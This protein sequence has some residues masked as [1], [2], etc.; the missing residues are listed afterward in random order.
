MH[1]GPEIWTSKSLLSHIR[2]LETDRPDRRL[3]F[4]IGAGASV[5]SGIP[6]G[7]RLV[8]RWLN[9]L[10]ER[11]CHGKEPLQEWATE[12]NL[13][14]P[15]FDYS[16]RAEFYPQVFERRYRR[17]R[18][19]GYEALEKIMDRAKPSFG[20]SVLAQI[21]A[22]KRHNVVVTT[23]FDN[24]VADAM[25][26]YSGRHPLMVGHE[27]LSGYAR[28]RLSRPLV[29]KIHRDL[30]INPINDPAGTSELATGW[31]SA[32]TELFKHHT[33]IVIGY[34]GNDG[35]LMGFLETLPDDHI[36][37]GLFWTYRENSGKP[38]GRIADVVARHKGALVPIIGFDEFMLQLREIF[39]LE[40]LTEHI[41]KQAD[42]HL[43]RYREQTDNL[44]KTIDT[45]SRPPNRDTTEQTA[46][47]QAASSLAK[48]QH[49]WWEWE[50]K[51]RSEPDLNKREAIYLE[52]LSQFPDNLEL[53]GNLANFMMDI[54]QN[55]DEAER[56]YRHAFELAP[57]NA[58]NTGNFANFMTYIRKDHDEAERLYRRAL[59]LAP[60]NANNTGNF[61]SFMTSIR[62][63]YDEA[64]RLYRRAL[65]LD[66]DHANNTG[67]F[68]NFMTYIRKDH[69]EAE[70]LYRRTLELNPNHATNTGNFAG[71][72]LAQRDVAEANAQAR[73]AWNLNQGKANQSAAETGLY[74]ALSARLLGQDDL[75]ALARIKALV[76]TGFH[77]EPWFFDAVLERAAP[78][79]D[80][81]TQSFYRTLANAILDETRVSE[82]EAYPHWTKIVPADPESMV[83]WDTPIPDLTASGHSCPP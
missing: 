41:Q 78:T 26:T 24:L 54:R 70:R 6:V 45:A 3:V 50:L 67:N 48:Q 83:E 27:S 38:E 64:E 25:A 40:D 31:E 80:P 57:D 76:L 63:D 71:F 10:H 35:S 75:P 47:R 42:E 49:S 8:E 33:P 51:A 29:A 15:N 2:N 30:F 66:P 5:T 59:E 72:L 20:Y 81:D 16:R 34:G 28:A 39:E 69:G 14:I 19:E 55:H 17:D 44:L 12:Q 43:K 18:S 73:Q 58:N 53:T 21:M 52:G 23:N 36:P 65:E 74:L 11:L 32:L 77:R 79:C 7:V 1:S 61:A 37:G 82:L 4:I 60:D 22:T 62:K 9:E 56:L 46:V 13:G 68:A